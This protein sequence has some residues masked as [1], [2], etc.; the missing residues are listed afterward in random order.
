MLGW[1]FTFAIPG[2]QVL[3]PPVWGVEDRD[4]ALKYAEA[5]ARAA[6]FEITGL[7]QDRRGEN[8]G[9]RRF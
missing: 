7:V 6:G 1:R 2:G 3:W 9:T 4:E 8:C 5:R